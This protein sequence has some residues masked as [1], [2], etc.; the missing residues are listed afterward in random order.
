MTDYMQL[1]GCLIHG[2][3]A[4]A[5]LQQQGLVALNCTLTPTNVIMKPKRFQI[6]A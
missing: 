6:N 5:P 1:S 3:E 4:T 2:N